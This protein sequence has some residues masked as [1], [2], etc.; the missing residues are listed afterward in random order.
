VGSPSSFGVRIGAVTHEIP[1]LAVRGLQCVA[2]E[3]EGEGR[4]ETARF[5]D[6]KKGK[7]GETMEDHQDFVA[8]N[9]RKV[10]RHFS[11]MGEKEG[12][13]WVLRRHRAKYGGEQLLR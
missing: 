4:P 9:G 6:Q 8:G 2:I 12:E 7:R 11:P 13:G 10:A 5:R 1:L 3:G